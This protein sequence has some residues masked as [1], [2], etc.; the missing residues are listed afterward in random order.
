MSL[1][2]VHNAL[3]TFLFQYSLHSFCAIVRGYQV[4]NTVAW[5]NWLVSRSRG[6]LQT[7]W[8]KIG[9]GLNHM[10]YCLLITC[11]CVCYDYN[12]CT[13]GGTCVHCDYSN[14]ICMWYAIGQ[15]VY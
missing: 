2:K 1:H 9:G 4:S 10:F 12:Q 14:G 11:S 6:G 5:A 13:C 3:I 8:Y 15:Y 7:G